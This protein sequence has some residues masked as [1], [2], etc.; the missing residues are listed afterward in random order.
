MNKHNLRKK[1]FRFNNKNKENKDNNLNNNYY[2]N[3]NKNNNNKNNNKN[4]II[5]MNTERKPIKKYS[6][7]SNNLGYD[8][9]NINKSRDYL[10][11]NKQNNNEAPYNKI[12][13]NKGLISSSN[14]ALVNN[15]KI[16][17]L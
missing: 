8:D 13:F 1:D 9:K 7:F 4:N 2:S 14:F 3:K 5:E 17:I 12:L 15:S 10:F 11:P 6:I 16:K